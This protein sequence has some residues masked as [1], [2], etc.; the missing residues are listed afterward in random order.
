MLWLRS[1]YN[2]LYINNYYTSCSTEQ[3]TLFD[4]YRGFYTER[5]YFTF[6]FQS[7]SWPLLSTFWTSRNVWKHIVDHWIAGVSCLKVM[8]KNRHKED[9]KIMKREKTGAYHLLMVQTNCSVQL[10]KSLI[11]I[12][13][14]AAV[15]SLWNVCCKFHNYYSIYL[16][17]ESQC[18]SP[19]ANKQNGLS[20]WSEQGC[21][22][23]HMALCGSTTACCVCKPQADSR[24]VSA[25]WWMK[26]RPQSPVDELHH[27]SHLHRGAHLPL[28]KNLNSSAMFCVFPSQLS[29]FN[30]DDGCCGAAESECFL[31]QPTQRAE[32]VTVKNLCYSHLVATVAIQLSC[33]KWWT[34]NM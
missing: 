18:C 26:L 10:S 14:C 12:Y 22:F 28:S 3:S 13:L 15:F 9:L 17:T 32:W 24:N 4:A 34:Y 31:W 23:D 8:F 16:T 30:E 2:M 21:Q 19:L 29:G 11:W 5:V 20:V 1:L 25:R 33:Q 27:G 6:Q 7:F